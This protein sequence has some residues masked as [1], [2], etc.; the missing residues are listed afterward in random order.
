MKRLS[1][2]TSGIMLGAC[3]FVAAAWITPSTF[4]QDGESPQTPVVEAPDNES[5]GGGD[6][7]RGGG[8]RIG[9]AQGSGGPP[10]ASDRNGA[11]RMAG[12]SRRWRNPSEEDITA[13]LQVVGEL[14]PEWRNTLTTLKSEEPEAFQ[15]AIMRHGR[16]FWQ[17]VELRE[18]NPSLYALRLEEIRTQERLRRLARAYRESVDV[19]PSAE[20]DR[21]LEELKQLALVQIDLQLRV[22]GEELAAMDE[23]LKRLRL[24]LL[25]EL[26]DRNARAEALLERLIQPR[27]EGELEDRPDDRPRSRPGSG[28]ML[29]G[30]GRGPVAPLSSDDGASS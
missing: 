25:E 28:G 15:Q 27:P 19:G 30:G 10:R 5:S 7:R 1:K 11:S 24:E 3:V 4:A 22:R 26:D 23:A 8:R 29:R 18:Q 14:N 21:M 2:R 13:L 20:S 12:W 6:A 9:E 16:R 17:L